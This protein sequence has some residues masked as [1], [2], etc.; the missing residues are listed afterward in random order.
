M[1]LRNGLAT[2]TGW[3]FF[4]GA[5]D[6]DQIATTGSSFMIGNGYLGYRGTLAEWGPDELVGCI[7]ADTWDTASEGAL[8]ELCNVPNG[9]FLAASV[10]G[11][12][13]PVSGT[14]DFERRVDLRSGLFS[15]RSGWRGEGG[16]PVSLVEERF[17]SMD[18]VR[19]VVSRTRVTAHAP[20]ALTIVTGIDGNVA[21]LTDP[22]VISDLGGRVGGRRG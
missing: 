14:H 12:P 5:L 8:T 1:E 19:L 11:V 10:D 18:D 3:E 7:V 9:L 20:C 13:V 2:E 22:W 6:P 17:A 16:V 4:E 21:L 15:R